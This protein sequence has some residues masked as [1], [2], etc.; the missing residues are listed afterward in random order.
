MKI[1]F[2]RSCFIFAFIGGMFAQNQ[3]EKLKMSGPEVQNIMQ[4]TWKTEAQYER[5][6][7]TPNGGT[8]LGTETWRPGPGGM[9]VIEGNLVRKTRKDR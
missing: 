7:Y 5:T 1:T 2:I 8:A 4:G 9:S 3:P 6:E